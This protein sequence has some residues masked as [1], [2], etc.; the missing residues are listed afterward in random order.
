[1]RRENVMKIRETQTIR[2]LQA[3][4]KKLVFRPGE[5]RWRLPGPIVAVLM[6][7]HLRSRLSE[8]RARAQKKPPETK[9]GDEKMARSPV[10]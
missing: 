5:T 10:Q 3:I 9:S 2:R 7:N 8:I 1:M 6:G 4:Y